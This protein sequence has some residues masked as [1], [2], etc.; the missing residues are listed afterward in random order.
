MTINDKIRNEKLI[1]DISRETTKVLVVLSEKNNK[2]DH[3]TGEEIIYY[4]IIIILLIAFLLSF[5]NSFKETNIN[6]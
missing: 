1:Y 6:N 5:K 3:I 2:Y 4:H